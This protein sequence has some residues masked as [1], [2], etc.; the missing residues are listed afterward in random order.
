MS[1]VLLQKMVYH[2]VV[3]NMMHFWQNIMER[4]C[5]IIFS[6]LFIIPC[7]Y[8]WNLGLFV[9]LL[10][11]IDDERKWKIQKMCRKNSTECIVHQSTNSKWINWGNDN[12]LT[13][14]TCGRIK[15]SQFFNNSSRWNKRQT[16]SVAFRF[17]NKNGDVGTYFYFLYHIL[18]IIL[19]FFF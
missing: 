10:F 17:V 4:V 1:F 19:C 9:D 2:F 7:I 13:K 12:M 16:L 11:T 18:K 8:I 3:E 15:W 6:I 5:A 14:K